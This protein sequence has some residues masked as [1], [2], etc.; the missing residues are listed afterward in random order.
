MDPQAIKIYITVWLVSVIP[1]K[2]V[3]DTGEACITSISDICEAL[4]LL[5]MKVLQI[6]I[7]LIR[8]RVDF[9]I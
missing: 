5:L 8:I 4:S 1:V 3:N 2:H 7:L 9:S 6:Q